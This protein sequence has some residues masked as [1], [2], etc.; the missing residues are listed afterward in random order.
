MVYAVRDQMKDAYPELVDSADRVS[1][2]V[3]GEEVRFAHTLDFRPQAAGGRFR[4]AARTK[5]VKQPRSSAVYPGEKCVQALRHVRPAAR[6]HDRCGRDQGSP[7]TRQ[8]ST[9]PW[10][11]ARA[12]LRLLER[13]SGESA[14]SP[15][16]QKLPPTG[17]E[18]YLRTESHDS[19]VLAIIDPHGQGVQQLKPGEQGEIVL[20]RT[21]FYAEAAGRWAT[22]AGST[23][24]ITTPWSPT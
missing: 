1:T 16:F 18:G 12:R 3:Q 14:A 21:P 19:E 23:T 5:R 8:V 20:D 24:A 10:T 4:P 22:S 2:V 6:L 11:A 15:A 13:W 7:S 9:P 17:F